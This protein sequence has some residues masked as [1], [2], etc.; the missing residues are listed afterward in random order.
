MLGMS[1]C[2]TVPDSPAAHRVVDETRQTAQLMQDREQ[3][4]VALRAELASTRI[5]AAKQEAELQE[6][7]VTVM[8]LRQDHR[9]SQ[10]TLLE[11][12]H[13]IEARNAELASL[14]SERDHL[15]HTVESTSTSV[16]QLATLQ[17]T[18]ASLSQELATVKQSLT[19]VA[20]RPES[21]AVQGRMGRSLGPRPG[22][23]T[24]SHR[25]TG[26][27]IIPVVQVLSE[28]ADQSKPAWITVQPGE[29][30]WL[31]ARKH[32]TT[33]AALRAANGLQGDQ[34]MVGEALR[35]P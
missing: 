15:A 31:L 25:D 17:E 20:N 33:I 18:V 27:R 22:S 32:K 2:A 24:G 6:L 26:D 9:E 10:Q 30:L 16:D 11:A 23:L 34:L 8:Q 29:S 4:M 19:V 14:K 13:T 21:A 7:R 35:L 12:K 1:S 28:P 5:A 3:A